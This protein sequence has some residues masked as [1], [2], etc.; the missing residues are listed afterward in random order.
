MYENSSQFKIS[1]IIENSEPMLMKNE[2][3][4][5]PVS[6]QYV[7]E[8]SPLLTCVLVFSYL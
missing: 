1:Y 3:H 2:T 4:A 7:F 5:N 6:D 8:N